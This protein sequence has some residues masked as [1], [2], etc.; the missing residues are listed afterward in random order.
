MPN[1][2]YKK[3]IHKNLPE[4][5]ESTLTRVVRKIK[6]ATKEA[7]EKEQQLQKLQMQISF[8]AK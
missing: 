6:L 2:I 4:Q 7:E 8:I 1:Q 5:M 3:R